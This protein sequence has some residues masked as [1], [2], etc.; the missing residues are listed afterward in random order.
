MIF[1]AESMTKKFFPF[2]IKTNSVDYK[3]LG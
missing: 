1:N 3:S 2:L